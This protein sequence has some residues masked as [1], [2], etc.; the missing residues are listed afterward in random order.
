M[1]RFLLTRLTQA[2][3]TLFIL[4]LVIFLLSR[5]VGN[6]ADILLPVDAP[7]EA[8]ARLIRDLG[9]DL[10]IHEQYAVYLWDLIRGDF[11]VSVRSRESVSELIAARLPS[12]MILASAAMIFATAAAV[13]LGMVSALNR[14]RPL[15]SFAK[16]LALLG[17]SVPAFWLGILLIQLFAVNLRWLPPSGT[18]T[19]L[20]YVMPGFTMSL[21]VLAGMTRLLRTSMLEVLDS[22]FVRFARSKGLPERTVLFRHALRNAL[23]PLV[24]FGGIYFAI[25]VTTAIVTEVVFAWPGIG[26]LAYNAIVLRDFPLMQGVV[27]TIGVVV[28]SVSLIIDLLYAV[29]DPRIRYGRSG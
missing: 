4:S 24:S 2:V 16:G 14:G 7:P 26:R 21:F 22:E 9:L 19:A 8:R 15:D 29:L 18:G 3:V 1:R 28:I 13:P 12:S 20:H 17:Q 23:V 25:L 10:P 6:P 27:L 11:G 5:I